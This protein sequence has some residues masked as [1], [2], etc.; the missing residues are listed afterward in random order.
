MHSI[1]YAHNAA[2]HMHVITSSPSQQAPGSRCAGR[3]LPCWFLRHG[4]CILLLRTCRIW[5]DVLA[6][7][8]GSFGRR[9]ECH[10]ASRPHPARFGA[11][12]AWHG[13]AE[14]G[15]VNVMIVMA[16]SVALRWCLIYTYVYIYI[17]ICVCVCVCIYIYIYIYILLHTRSCVA[18]GSLTC[19]ALSTRHHACMRT[20]THTSIHTYRRRSYVCR[21][22][23]WWRHHT[24]IRIYTLYIHTYIHTKVLRVSLEHT[25]SCMHSY[26]HSIHAYMGRS[27]VCRL[28]RTS[29]W[30]TRC[31]WRVECLCCI[32]CHSKGVTSCPCTEIT[33]M[34]EYIH[35]LVS[36]D[37]PCGR[38]IHA[39]IHTCIH[40][41]LG[42]AN[43][44]ALRQIH[45]PRRMLIRG[46][47]I[48]IDQG[49]AAQVED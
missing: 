49:H 4:R 25:S 23:R 13:V 26:I 24:C 2:T 29:S 47:R 48:W 42:V 20:Y 43:R 16:A 34:H 22:E 38:Y 27:Y 31:W 12:H 11:A 32:H 45:A 7:L 18:M 1:S 35:A 14:F 9:S 46:I 3:R 15:P 36:E 8:Y 33:C 17:Y 37:E 41:Y 44:R 21:L 5:R 10:A 40:T 28:E 19:D 39:Y 30:S 6:H